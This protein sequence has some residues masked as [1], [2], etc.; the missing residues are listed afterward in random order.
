MSEE[1]F[2]VLETKR[3]ILR[4]I[5]KEDARNIFF[6]LSDPEVMKHY[7]LLPFERVEDAQNEIEWYQSI[8][9]NQTGRRWGITLKNED[10]VIG[11]CGYFN[12]KLQHR[13][14]EIG[15]E[16]SREYWGKGIASE[17]VQAVLNYGFEQ[18]KLHRVE[19]LIEPPNKASLK[20]VERLGFKREGL[21]RDYEWAGDSFDD[22]YMY[23]LLETDCQTKEKSSN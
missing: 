13:R 19:A 7:G 8:Q 16:L 14:A 6:Y 10:T 21:L 12:H 1:L 2:P 4:Q 17:A 20:L 15:Y 23:A 11:S 3:L 9:D 5:K 22:L 18:M